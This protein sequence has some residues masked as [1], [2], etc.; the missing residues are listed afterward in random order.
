MFGTLMVGGELIAA[1]LPA[2]EKT[3]KT[4]LI[5]AQAMSI[6]MLGLAVVFLVELSGIPRLAMALI[7]LAMLLSAALTILDKKRLLFYELTFIYAS[8]VSILLITFSHH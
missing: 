3:K 8:H 2:A 6:G 5:M 7:L 4:H 1:L